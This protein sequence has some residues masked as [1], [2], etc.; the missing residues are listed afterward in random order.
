[1]QQEELDWGDGY[2][3]SHDAAAGRPSG[4]QKELRGAVV[5]ASTEEQSQLC[6]ELLGEGALLVTVPPP[7]QEMRGRLGEVLEELVERELARM[8]APSPYLAAWSAMPEDAQARL[9]DQ[10]FRARTVGATGIAI[11]IGSLRALAAAALT[12][13]DSATLRWLADAAEEAPLV[14]LLD[15]ADLRIAGYAAPLPLGSLLAA[16]KPVWEATPSSSVSVVVGGASSAIAGA[17]EELDALDVD[18]TAIPDD[19]DDGPSLLTGD[20]ATMNDT[21][22]SSIDAG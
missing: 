8:G 2:R 16:R 21:R 7:G 18:A 4:G 22:V 19:D 14:L 1:M 20:D 13:D 12:P 11:A 6:T 17:A 10:L 3:P 5:F 15:D 9:A